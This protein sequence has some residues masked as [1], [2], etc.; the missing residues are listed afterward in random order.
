MNK[1]TKKAPGF[2][3]VVSAASLSL[4]REGK[5]IEEKRK[6]EGKGKEV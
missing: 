1:T 2:P 4:S 3:E 6:R 5:K